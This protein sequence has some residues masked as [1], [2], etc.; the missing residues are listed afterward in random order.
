MIICFRYTR[1][2]KM[3]FF[4]FKKYAKY[5]RINKKIRICD[6]QNQFLRF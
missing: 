4:L 6:V 5:I 2:Q 3:S 1:N